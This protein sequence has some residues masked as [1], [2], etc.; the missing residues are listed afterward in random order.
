MSSYLTFYGIP[1]KHKDE[2]ITLWSFS[3]NS[4]VYQRFNETGQVAF[5]GNDDTPKYSIVTSDICNDAIQSLKDEIK[6]FK[7]Q[8]KTYQELVDKSKTG[9]E[10]FDNIQS[11]NSF[12][13]DIKEFKH[14]IHFISA[15]EM[16]V[17]DTENDFTG[18]SQIVANVD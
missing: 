5:I 2:H 10:M 7:Q 16:L 3:R 12:K 4:Q 14:T 13:E 18:F 11:R 9:E 1:K 15:I 6:G 8:V 17:R